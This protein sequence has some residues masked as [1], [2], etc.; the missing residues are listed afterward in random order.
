MIRW[1]LWFAAI[2]VLYEIVAMVQDATEAITGLFVAAI[3]TGVVAAAWRNASIGCRVRA[4]ELAH[5]GGVPL[6]MIRDAF[7]VLWWTLRALTGRANLEGYFVRVPFAVPDDDDA[8]GQGRAALAIFGVSAAPN[9]VVADVDGRGELV[10]H[11]LYA[12]EQPAHSAQ[13][14]L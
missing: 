7:G 3:A 9:S 2:Y 13:W 4:R 1:A 6:R 11:K 8:F 5:L 12:S 10:I 14:P